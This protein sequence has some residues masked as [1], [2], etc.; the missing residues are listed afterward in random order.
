[1]CVHRL[2]RGSWGKG[3]GWRAHVVV[4][5]RAGSS[6]QNL[7]VALQEGMKAALKSLE[8]LQH[9][10]VLRRGR[11]AVGNPKGQ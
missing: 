2:P 11:V 5:V 6:T 8:L 9:L 7:I 3:E 4:V 1:M 10:D